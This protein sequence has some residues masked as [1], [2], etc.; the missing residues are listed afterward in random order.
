MEA[1]ILAGGLGTR[2]K[3]VVPDVPK[4]LAM[5]ANRPFLYYLLDHCIEQHVDRVILAT[6]HMHSQVETLIGNRYKS[7]EVNYSRELEPLGTGGAVRCALRSCK[8]E[9]VLVLNGDTLCKASYVSLFQS[10]LISALAMLLIK[11]SDTRRYGKVEVHEGMVCAFTE[12][13]SS[14][15]KGLINAG[16]YRVSQSVFDPYPLPEKFSFESDFLGRYTNALSPA[17]VVENAFF[18]DIGIPE[19]FQRAQVELLIGVTEMKR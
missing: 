9:D 6:G 15:G 19:D 8:E 10:T 18:I 1:I 3:S 12:K 17:A 13:A 4:C 5:V 11:V 14:K 7:L 16:V 2:L